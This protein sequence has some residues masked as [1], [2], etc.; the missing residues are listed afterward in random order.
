MKEY[1]VRVE[2]GDGHE[3]VLPCKTLKQA[4]RVYRERLGALPDELTREIVQEA[5]IELIEVLD[6]WTVTAPVPDEMQPPGRR[7]SSV[8]QAPMSRRRAGT[9]RSACRP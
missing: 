7:R 5:S 1:Q 8:R 4:Q 9:L 2:Y 3:E 6:Q